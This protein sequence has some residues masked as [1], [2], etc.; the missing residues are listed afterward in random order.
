[1]RP[2]R[3]GDPEFTRFHA[4]HLLSLGLCLPIDGVTVGLAEQYLESVLTTVELAVRAEEKSRCR[5]HVREALG[6]DRDR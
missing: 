1:M 3:F 4:A 6:L 2:P 5:E